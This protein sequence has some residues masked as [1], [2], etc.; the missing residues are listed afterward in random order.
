MIKEWR[1]RPD[2]WPARARPVIHSGCGVRAAAGAWRI[3]YAVVPRWRSRSVAV[4]LLAIVAPIVSSFHAVG[5]EALR[6][7]IAN[8]FKG[9]GKQMLDNHN[10]LRHADVSGSAGPRLVA[11]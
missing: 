8:G 4:I 9:T 1:V 5:Q 2:K 6:P 7:L 3:V 10:G 11:S